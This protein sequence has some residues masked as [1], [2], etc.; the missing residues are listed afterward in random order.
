MWSSSAARRRVRLR[1]PRL[2]VPKLL[3]PKVAVVPSMPCPL[4]AEEGQCLRTHSILARTVKP[5]RPCRPDCN[6]YHRRHLPTY[7][8]GRT[9]AEKNAHANLHTGTPGRLGPKSS[10]HGKT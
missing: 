9:R 10:Q 7:K 2:T 5:S 1:C 3:V 6:S 4:C 8:R